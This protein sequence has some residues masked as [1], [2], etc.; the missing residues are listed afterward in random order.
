M[1]LATPVSATLDDLMQ[2]D[3]KAEL[4]GGRIVRFMPSGHLPSR[5]ALLIAMSLEIWSKQTRAGTAY[6]DGIGF[7]IRPPLSGG[8]ESFSPDASFR[9]GPAPARRMRFVDGPPTL[10]V[11]VRS[12][13]DYGP[14]AEQNLTEKRSD[15]FEAG[16][17]VVWDVDLVGE[18]I[19][20]Y[21]HTDPTNPQVFG[22][23]DMADAE[24]AAPGW[25]LPVSQLFSETA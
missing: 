2:V 12:E 11:E 23:D 13:G 3:G 18:V 20:C 5:V 4:I 14:L 24:S 15:Y 21:R 19:R 16:T 22:V 7:A 8:R 1:S 9:A 10:A 6:G 17:L 25:R